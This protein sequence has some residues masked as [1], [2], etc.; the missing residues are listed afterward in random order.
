MGVEIQQ[1][2]NQAGAKFPVIIITAH[3]AASVREE[4]MSH[5][6]VAYLRKTVDAGVLVSA[7]MFA[8]IRFREGHKVTAR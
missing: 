5:G 6:A 3:D 8:T 2:L 1:A 7:V 4:A